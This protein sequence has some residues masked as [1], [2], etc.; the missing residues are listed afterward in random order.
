M[1]SKTLERKS[2]SRRQFLTSSSAALLGTVELGFA[3]RENSGK[4]EKRFRVID[5]HQHVFNSKLQGTQGIPKYYPESTV[6]SLLSL[7]DQGGVD[8]GFLISYNA[9]DVASEIRS[10]GYNPV[11]LLP[12]SNKQYQFSSWKAHKDRFWWFPDH[13][14]PLREGYLETLESDFEKGASGIKLLPI[15]HGLLPDHAG[16]RPVYE[17]CLRRRK[18]IIL[19]LSWWYFGKYP[20]YNESR[21]RQELAN[22][23]KTFGDYAKLLDP[24]FQQ[25]SSVPFSLAHCGTARVREDYKD[26]FGLMARHANVSCDLA[27]I[28]DYSPTFIQ[29]LVSFCRETRKPLLWGLLSVFEAHEMEPF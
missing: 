17:L 11:E 4:L 12:V 20:V 15:F 27:A 16:W 5:T 21:E 29:E 22:S 24:V 6:E 26:I 2:I 10:R 7:M 23:F 25:F 19:D 18:P 13:I 3:Q 28:M 1:K 14:N 8:K 9:E